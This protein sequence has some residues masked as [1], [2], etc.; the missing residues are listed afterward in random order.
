MSKFCPN[1]GTMGADEAN[2]CGNCGYRFAQPAQPVN[3]QPVNPQPAYQQ[4]TY[5]Q[6]VQQPA[7]PFSPVGGQGGMKSA[8]LSKQGFPKSK[9]FVIIATLL[10]IYATFIYFMETIVL[11]YD[12]EVEFSESFFSYLEDDGG[13]FLVFIPVVVGI[14]ALILDLLSICLKKFGRTIKQIPQMIIAFLNLCFYGFLVFAFRDDLGY[15][16]EFKE[17]L[18]EMD[19]SYS[20]G[21]GTMIF[22]TIAIFALMITAAVFQKK[23]K[24]AE[25]AAMMNF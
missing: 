23:E 10:Q 11:K 21:L 19:A 8:L 12:G 24:K 14:I 6:P 15:G 13:E 25:R 16:R 2:V 3:P 18:K 9:I 20:D 22:V 7:Y 17:F 4:P 1:C 5:Q